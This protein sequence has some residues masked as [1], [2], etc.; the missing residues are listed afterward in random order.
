VRK[1]VT[2]FLSNDIDPGMTAGGGH[3]SCELANSKVQ[4]R[5]RGQRFRATAEEGKLKQRHLPTRG[6]SSER[7][8]EFFGPMKAQLSGVHATMRLTRI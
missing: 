7:P 8:P 2:F 1:A 3:L 4:Q 6:E 5:R